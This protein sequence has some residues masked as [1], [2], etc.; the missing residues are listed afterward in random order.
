MSQLQPVSHRVMAHPLAPDAKVH[1]IG[2]VTANGAK[3]PEFVH[4][5]LPLPPRW[6]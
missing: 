1:R 5:P 3:Q 6:V 4:P 2:R